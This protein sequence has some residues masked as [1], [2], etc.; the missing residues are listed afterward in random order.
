[1]KAIKSLFN[2]CHR[3]TKGNAYNAKDAKSERREDNNKEI[4]GKADPRKN[5]RNES[6]SQEGQKNRYYGQYRAVQ[7]MIFQMSI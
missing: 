3:E 5:I 2:S 6:Y 1:M 7:G 4:D